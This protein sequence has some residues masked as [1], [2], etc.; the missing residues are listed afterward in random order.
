MS[1]DVQIKYD[2]R[3]YAPFG[4]SKPP[5]EAYI[6]FDGYE[7]QKVRDRVLRWREACDRTW[8]WMGLARHLLATNRECQDLSDEELNQFRKDL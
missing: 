8:D 5:R 1:D 4:L 2:P 3:L 6:V 7:T